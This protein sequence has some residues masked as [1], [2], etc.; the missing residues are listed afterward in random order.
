MSATLPESRRSLN[1]SKVCTHRTRSRLV[2]A[3]HEAPLCHVCEPRCSALDVRG[4]IVEGFIDGVGESVKALFS[5]DR[6]SC[7]GVFFEETAS[8]LAPGPSASNFAEPIAAFGAQL[9]M[10]RALNY[11]ASRPNVLARIIHQRL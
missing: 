1:W 5:P 3:R 4:A 9:E 7:I 2:F 8:N 10:N 6:S 11:A